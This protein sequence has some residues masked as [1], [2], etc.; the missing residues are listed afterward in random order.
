MTAFDVI[1]GKLKRHM[2]VATVRDIF[3]VVLDEYDNMEVYLTS[4]ADIVECTGFER[5]LAK[6]HAGME[7]THSRGE[8]KVQHRLLAEPQAEPRPT[9]AAVAE[10]S[11]SESV[12]PRFWTKK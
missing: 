9:T 12:L 5:G 3:D 6:V 8:R 10:R 1:T 7:A 2:M 11:R 4:D